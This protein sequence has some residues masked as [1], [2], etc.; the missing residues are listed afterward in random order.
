MKINGVEYGWSMIRISSVSDLNI[1]EDSEVLWGC[2]AIEWNKKR[3][4]K[5]QYGIG[6]KARKVGFGNEECSASITL[7]TSAQIGLRGNLNTLLGLGMFDLTIT[8]MSEF[9]QEDI[10]VGSNVVI[11]KGCTF[12]EDGSSFKQGDTDAEK[13][14]ELQPL[15]IKFNND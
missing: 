8:F 14:F 10:A 9:D 4:R 5:N 15:D 7:K 3:E 11:L 13:T 6:H 1:A 2:T 12:T